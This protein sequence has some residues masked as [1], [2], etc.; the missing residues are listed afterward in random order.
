MNDSSQKGKLVSELGGTEEQIE[1]VRILN[2]KY[3]CHHIIAFI[4]KTKFDRVWT[5]ALW[6]VMKKQIIEGN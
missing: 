5:D 2:E 6:L 1:K 4:D 3:R